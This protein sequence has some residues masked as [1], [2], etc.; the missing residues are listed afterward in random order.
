[1]PVRETFWNIPAWLQLATY[2]AGLLAVAIAAVGVAQRTRLWLGGKPAQRFDRPAERLRGLI[3]HGILQQRTLSE[4]YPGIMHLCLFWGMIMLF[5]GTA[6]AT[7]DWDV[8]RLLGGFQFLAGGVYVAYELVLDL[9]GLLVLAGVALAAYRRFIVRPDRLRSSLSTRHQRDDVYALAML[10]LLA[11]TG[12]LIE[13][14]RIAVTQPDWAT[15]S[16]VGSF[17]AQAMLRLGDTADVRLHSLLWITHALLAFGAIAL[18]PFTKFFHIVTSPANIFLRDLGPLGAIEPIRDLEQAE[19]FGAG[20]MTHWS[21]KQRLDFDAC[22]RC[23]RC[24]AVCPAHATGKPLSPQNVILKLGDFMHE[25]KGPDR[26]ARSMHGDV[27]SADELWDCTTCGACLAACPVFIDQLGAI[28]EMRRFLTMSE[29]AVS[30]NLNLAMTNME[31]SGNPYGLPRSQRAA[32]AQGLDI[33]T[34]AEASAAVDILYWVG[35]AA[36]YDDRNKKVARAFAH[37]LQ[38]AGVRFAILG[39]EESCT[40]DAARR[41]GNEYL[42]QMLAQENIDTLNRY[43]VKRIVTSCPH[44]L[45]TLKHEYP[46]FGGN[47]DVVHHS[48]LIAELIDGGQ[49]RLNRDAAGQSTV[50]HD[51]CYLG[52]YNQIYASPRQIISQVTG[53][54]VLD[55]SRSHAQSFCCGAGGARNW[56][57][58]SRGTRINQSR[59]SEALATAAGTLAVA[60]PFCM[61]MM[62]DGVRAV[63]AAGER[64]MPVLDIAEVVAGRLLKDAAS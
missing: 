43:K 27:V 18:V 30:R 31:R 11:V 55:M 15:W 12:Y 42:F 24:Q 9:F 13:G 4:R 37:I 54:T 51:P 59:A 41:A 39:T 32:W 58:E 52:R 47:Y 22:T 61:G 45:N 53:R 16:P 21:W 60:C 29:G 17:I 10:A 23:G 64:D 2:L 8:T 14:L 46:Q 7:L 62:T 19:S 3:V 28:V 35:C 63:T 48:E 56:M 6:L 20:D 36:A 26:P 25:R 50:Y 34:M 49:L 5:A 33:P 38:A 57:E 44:C 40:G 1:M